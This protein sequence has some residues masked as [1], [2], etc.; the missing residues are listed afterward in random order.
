MTAATGDATKPE[1]LAL[2]LAGH[3]VVVSA[4]NPGR[5]PTGEGTASIIRAVK[6]VGDARLLVVGGA[7]S[8]QVD[9]GGRLVDQPDFPAA[10]KE[11][12]LKTAAFLDALRAEPDLDWTFVSPAAEL[13]SGERRGRYRIGEDRLLTDE[14]GASRIS[15]ED[16]AVAMLD[17]IEQPRHRRR[18][19]SVAY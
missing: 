9:S 14:Q 18:R 1:A 6:Q 16:Y 11:G 3:E 17:E 4:F 5:D 7:G 10:W 13:S 19:I 2:L 12:A 8:L 15:L